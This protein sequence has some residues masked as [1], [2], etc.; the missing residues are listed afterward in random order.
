[1]RQPLGYLLKHVR[2]DRDGIDHLIAKLKSLDLTAKVK[3]APQINLLLFFLAAILPMKSFSF[4]SLLLGT[5]ARFKR[6]DQMLAFT[7]RPLPAYDL[8]VIT[9][10]LLDPRIATTQEVDKL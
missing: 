4:K 3:S 2:K 8:G 7:S 1:M 10:G 5:S 6:R 9:L